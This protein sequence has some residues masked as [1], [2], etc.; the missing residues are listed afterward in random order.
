[1]K[2]PISW[3]T[4]YVDIEKNVQQLGHDL[5]MAGLEVAGITLVGEGWDED[6]LLV[7][8]IVEISPH[9]DADKL[10]LPTIHL[11]NDETIRVVC[12]APNIEIGQKIAFAKEGT[13]LV[14]PRNG[15][16]E[17]LKATVIRGV[18]SKGMVCSALELGLSDEHDGILVLDPDIEV[19]LSLSSVLSDQIIETELT[20]NRPDCLSIIGTAY[21]VAAL[22]ST[23]VREPIVSNRIAEHVGPQTLSVQIS[24]PGL[25]KRY[26]G[27]VIKGINIFESPQWLK[28][29]LEKSNQRSINNL[30]DITNFVM[31]EYG[32][33]L[34]AFDLNK[35]DG[36][37][38][39]VRV[40]NAGE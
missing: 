5:T 28:D 31:L 2:I 8:E 4:K 19:G 10:R 17:R 13:T 35:I 14:N 30:V 11:G 3:L 25:C 16:A 26:V 37:Q 27:A 15:K 39:K 23:N 21:E 36:G 12:G 22:Q 24:D 20:P 6:N 7:G 40:A 1:M 38:I 34:H 18:E 32:Q 29:A 9:P 33:P